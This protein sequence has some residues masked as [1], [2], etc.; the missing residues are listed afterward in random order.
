MRFGSSFLGGAVWTLLAVAVVITIVALMRA[1]RRRTYRRAWHAQWL[2]HRQSL[3]HGPV[4]LALDMRYARGEIGR[5]D[6]LL[7]RAA[8]L[9][10]QA[11]AA[12]NTPQSPAQPT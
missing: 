8:L 10:A 3:R 9:S 12:P 1:G 2:D 6:Y 11:S 5:D 4:L 7:R